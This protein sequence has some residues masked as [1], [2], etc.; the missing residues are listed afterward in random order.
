MNNQDY[1]KSPKIFTDTFKSITGIL[2]LTSSFL[3]ILCI[4]SFN[5]KD[6]GWGVSSSFEPT[7]YLGYLGSYFSSFIIKQLGFY[8]GLI[9]SFIILFLG[10]KLIKGYKF[11]LIFYKIIGLF[12]LLCLSG[13]LSHSINQI[14]KEFSN[15]YFF[16][17]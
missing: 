6:P 14:F 7:N 16:H 13:L 2:F 8:S 11:K 4:Y 5:P 17:K 12:F 3:I 1:T 15:H 9:L 10:T